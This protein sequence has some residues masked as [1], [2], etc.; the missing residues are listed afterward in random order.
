MNIFELFGRIAIDNKDASKA[1]IE[2]GKK[3]DKLA[4]TVNKAFTNVGKFAINCGKTVAKGLAVGSAAMTALVVKG[5]GLAGDLE[6][7]MGGAE[8]VFKE[9]ADSMKKTA[10][11]AYKSMGLAQA[12]YL[13]TANK[14]GALF[15]G[16]GYT[17]ED[18]ADITEK[19][20]QRAA[21]VASIMGIDVSTAMESI[22]GAA[23]GNFTMM[24]N[25]G[26]AVNDTALANYAL[27]KGIK[28]STS[29]MTTQE[30]VALAMELFLEKTA[31]AA[32][33]Y[34]KENET[35]AGSLTTA[36]AAFQNFLSGAGDADAL[37]DALVNAGDVITKNLNK[38]LPNLIKG[39]NKLI[40]KLTPK[41]PEIIRTTLPGIIEGA[42]E[43]LT[44]LA[45]ALPD[46]IDV[47]IDV[48]PET[49]KKLG[50]A[51]E[52]AWNLGVWP[53]IQKFF[54]SAFNIELP[55][56]H[57]FKME[58]RVWWDENI[59]P[60]IDD[61]KNWWNE[62][63]SDMLERVKTFGLNVGEAFF[64]AFKWLVDN[65][66]AVLG[67]LQG[68]AA[69]KI[70]NKL[71]GLIN[72]GA[73]ILGAG[74]G[75]AKAAGAG[76]GL[77]KA[78]GAG[79]G[80]AKAA[81]AGGGLAK[82]AGGLTKAAGFITKA[83]LVA[84]GLTAYVGLIRSKAD[85][86][87]EYVDK[88]LVSDDERPMTELRKA[89]GLEFLTRDG[90]TYSLGDSMYENSESGLPKGTFMLPWWDETKLRKELVN[91][92]NKA[93]KKNDLEGVETYAVL[94]QAFIDA[95]K[96]GLRGDDLQDAVNTAFKNIES[97]IPAI[98]GVEEANV[99]AQRYL[100]SYPLYQSIKFYAENYNPLL[101]EDGN[102]QSQSQGKGSKRTTAK[103]TSVEATNYVP[104]FAT[105]LDF[106]PY[107]N[108]LARLH[109]GETVLTRKDADAWRKG[110]TGGM[111]MLAAKFAEMQE[112]LLQVLEGI[113][114]QPIAVNVDSKTAAV[115]MAREM[116]K[117]IGNR[118]IQTLMGM[119]G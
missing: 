91:G 54:K 8:A 67:V 81:G 52:K 12:E 51:L 89:Y 46:M 88:N 32:G 116:T 75:L 5:M 72:A 16:V 94:N 96:E 60:V 115:L 13:A 63:G 34:A 111:A 86:F 15:Q 30:K 49:M 33:N 71:S 84:A 92:L 26:V 55:K 82:A 78:A 20:M 76:G 95:W 79:G 25:L 7:N 17:I 3:A 119:G 99:E 21:D 110:S 57:L 56:W 41:L 59:K 85:E 44:G 104:G 62:S 102:A 2:T 108:Y 48:L 6:Q 23:K 35:L 70:A 22:A 24:D 117:S 61:V 39:M 97:K 114:N 4:S 87:Q 109:Y 90:R 1:L 106:V 101:T 100:D 45:L 64:K 42:G 53:W 74:G 47:I 50:F 77:A 40:K 43:L 36:K 107:D 69:V 68:I 10:A 28:K 112:T 29:K 66:E 103:G 38:L 73:A 37:A 11:D 14:M 93:Y 98:I 9:F 105:G 118:N 83:G 19:A 27:E 65:K 113:R 58:L 80:L 31:Y 18:S